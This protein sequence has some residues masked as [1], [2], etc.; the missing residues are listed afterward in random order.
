M[1]TLKKP[2]PAAAGSGSNCRNKQQRGFTLIELMLSLSLTALLLGMLSAGVYSVVRDWDDNASGLDE[3]LD[4]TIAILQIERALQGAFPH[5]F[6]DTTT[7]G[8]LIY[9]TGERDHISW[10][11]SVS[12]QR[13]SGLFAWRLFSVPDEGVYLQLAPAFTDDPEQRLDDA[14]PTLLLQNYEASF[15]YL[16]EDLEFNKLW[17]DNWQGEERM[18]LPF[19]VHVLLT[20]VDARSNRKPLDIVAAI[21]A[22]QH[23]SLQPALL[24][25]SAQPLQMRRPAGA[26]AQEQL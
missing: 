18:M 14:E 4:E 1:Q 25:P 24:S 13:G 9:F 10:V 12:P 15:N 16:Y 19:A 20:P 3:T 2:F 6:R 5:S 21:A 22:N 11:S 7:L 17:Q 23:R 8:R 26:G